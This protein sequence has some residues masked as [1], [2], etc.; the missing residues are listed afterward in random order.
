VAFQREAKSK[1]GVG[2]AGDGALILACCQKKAEKKT[3]GLGAV[4]TK[5]RTICLLLLKYEGLRNMGTK[6]FTR[7]SYLA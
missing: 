1:S 2:G 7:I 4:Y 3:W 5:K 6:P